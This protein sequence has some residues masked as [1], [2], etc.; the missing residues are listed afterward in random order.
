MIANIQAKPYAFSFDPARTALIVIDMQRDF[1]A[2]GGFGEMLGND[3]SP[4]RQIIPAIASLI[5]AFRVKKMPVI[6][7]REGHLPD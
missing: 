3:I 2:T 5:E 7:T 1:C 4:T 6:H